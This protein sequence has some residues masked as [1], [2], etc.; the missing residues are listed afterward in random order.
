MLDFDPVAIALAWLL[1]GS[2]IWMLRDPQAITDTVL[3]GWVRRHHR[4]PPRGIVLAAHVIAILLW[5][6][7]V[8]RALMRLEPRR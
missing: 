2:V 8:D 7:V 5:P 3:R 4:L 6:R 1:A